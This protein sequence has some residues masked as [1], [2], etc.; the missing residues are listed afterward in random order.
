M[1][2]T[3]LKSHQFSPRRQL[4]CWLIPD[5]FNEFQH[6]LTHIECSVKLNSYPIIG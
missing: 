2:T 5:E 3:A 1:K 6:N 4:E